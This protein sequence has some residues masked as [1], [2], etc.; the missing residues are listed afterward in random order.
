M[1]L[2]ILLF[3][4]R[5]W[6]RQPSVY[7]FLLINALLIFGATVSD[8]IRVGGSMGNVHRNAPYV[9]ENYYALMS[10]FSLLMITSYMNGAAARDFM[11]KTYQI[12]FSTPV[13]KRDLLLGR[14]VGALMVSI[15]PFLGVSVGVLL[16]SLMPWVDTE[17]LGPV[18]WESHVLGLLVFIIPNLVFAGSIIFSI[19]AVTRST[20]L[21]FL[22]S[23]GL[24]VGY[25]I[26]L[27]LVG[28]IDNEFLG[29]MLDPFGVRTLAVQTKY[30]TVLERNS[31]T[32]GFDGVMLWNRCLWM[33]LG[34]V[35]FGVTYRGFRFTEKAKAGKR[36]ESDETPERH[37]VPLA[38]GVIRP[39]ADGGS[40]VRKLLGQ[41]KLEIISLMKNMAFL[42][43]MIFGA[44][45]L[46]TNLAYATDAGYG[47]S[48]FPVSYTMIDIIQGGLYLYIIAIITFYSGAIVWKER[49]AKVN[50]IYDALPH[51]DWIPMLSKTIAMTAMIMIV[52]VV[53]AFTGMVTQI[54]H[55][56]RDLRPEVYAVQLLVLDATKFLSLII[57]SVCVHS[58]VNNRYLGYFVFI[59][60]IVAN[61][62]VWQALDVSSN[63]LIYGAT[64]NLTYSDMNG[65]GPFLTAKLA[66]KAYWFLFGC[67]LLV[68][69]YLY[70][71]R[72]REDGFAVRTTLAVRRFRG[73]RTITI[74]L[75]IL[76]LGCGSW[77][78]VHTKV[79]NTYKS[80]DEME[81][82]Q[83]EYERLYKKF[84]GRNQPRIHALDYHIELYPERR[85][86]MVT[87]MSTVRNTGSSAIDSLYFTLPPSYRSEMEIPGARILLMDTVRKFSIYRLSSPMQPGD[88]LTMRMSMKFEPR[89]I[90]N[91]VTQTSI[92]NNGTFFNNA[93]ILP[94]IGYQPDYEMSDKNDRRKHGMPPRA[95]V[96]RLSDDPSARMNT[97]LTN[98]SDWV[99]VRSVFGTAG[100]Q[101]AI[102]PGSL[103]REWTAGGRNYFEYELDHPSMNFYSF[104]SASYQVKRREHKGV[105]LEV[106]YDKRHEYNVD[107]MLMS[108]EKSVDYYSENFGPY[109]HK[110]ARI[111]EFPRYAGFAQA[112]PGTMPYSESIGFIANLEDS[113]S[114]DMVTYVVAHEM[115]HQWWAHQV[116]GANMQGATLLS[117]S[118]SQYS[119]LMVMERMYGKEQMHKFLRYEMDA[120]LRSRGRE[121]EKES[122][123]LDIENQGYIHY[124][125]ASVVFYHLREMLGDSTV[126]DALKDLVANFAYKGPPYPNSMELFRRIEG[127]TPDSLKYMLN[128]LFRRI[129]LFDN[130]AVAA[131]CNE[132]TGGYQTTITVRVA[133][134]YADSIGR[135]TPAK[136][137]DWVDIAV[138]DKPTNGR[139][140]GSM[141]GSQRVWLNSEGVKT[142]T[143]RTKQRPTTAG[144]DPFYYLID[145]VPD[146]NMKDVK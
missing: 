4:L 130:R 100:D 114:I 16:G 24:L 60:I 77:L 29:S 80:E 26:A 71:T 5:Y 122:A 6:L 73:V 65:F 20:L 36:G 76:W 135:E 83:I 53:S 49:D 18:Y 103:R 40:N 19:A 138:F 66:F 94:T 106:Y 46:I 105:R 145:R 43:L 93:D 136:L 39:D 8:E 2:S 12:L 146:D 69:T 126:N 48:S 62:F 127:R 87:C 109:K 140:R 15:V 125:K 75:L 70:W 41:T 88:S 82:A 37:R 57:L 21:S 129:T 13:R 47:N 64:P 139:K 134:M 144:I 14:F 52:L 42:V 61:A 81:S 25:I 78:Y 90:E 113:A 95:R 111:I 120:Y 32:L 54:L 101:I 132:V 133:K 131:T 22:G 30:W 27:T 107:K 108:M 74:G 99:R 102:A 44:V 3:E 9:V 59:V 1:F 79:I 121:S 89:G 116:V 115:G 86:L 23:I 68:V 97:Y 10:I 128:D 124:N 33:A 110:Q 112:F 35:I 96:P 56:F 17:V 34:A 84:E 51:P 50:D 31:M 63:L 141:L 28:D 67:L 72:G 104:M 45:N 92:V 38:L 98:N 137:N 118:L 85:A 142:F 91:E 55:G 123:L 7:I 11:E 119:A 58:L 143:L 117:E